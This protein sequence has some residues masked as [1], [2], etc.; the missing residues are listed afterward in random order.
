MVRREAYADD[1]AQYRVRVE[2]DAVLA[3]GD[4]LRSA[5][6]PTFGPPF[7]G[8]GG[9]LSMIP[10]LDTRVDAPS[11]EHACDVVGSYLP[12]GAHVVGANPLSR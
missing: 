3:A 9:N 10:I 2:G 5:A 11:A 6:M 8:Y 1:M 4:S 7:A 12:V